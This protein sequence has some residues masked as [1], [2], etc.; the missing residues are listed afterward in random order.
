MILD[1]INLYVSDLDLSRQFYDALLPSEGLALVRDFKDIAV[2]YGS[3]NYAVLALVRRDGEIQAT[4]LAFRLNDRADVDRLYRKA[5]QA[6]GL[7]HGPPGLR[8]HYHPHYSAGFVLDP[9]R[10]VLEFVCHD[11]PDG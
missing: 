7:D 11:E 10:H 4:H 9:D 6:G 8:P 3:S 5:L 2:G 1:H